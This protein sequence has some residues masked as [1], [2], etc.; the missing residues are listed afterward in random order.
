MRLY[1]ED[2]G[3]KAGKAVERFCDQQ[4][5]AFGKDKNIAGILQIL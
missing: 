4:S 2:W 3:Q 5:F 1:G